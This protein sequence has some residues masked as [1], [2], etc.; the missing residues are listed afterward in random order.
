MNVE[1]LSQ[2]EL[3]P[4]DAGDHVSVI[5]DFDDGGDLGVEMSNGRLVR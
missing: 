2:D 5:A 3:A 4:I 1:G